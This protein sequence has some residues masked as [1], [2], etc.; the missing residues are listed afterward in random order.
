MQI[1]LL[2]IVGILSASTLCYSD[3]KNIQNLEG[4]FSSSYVEY[5]ADDG[6]TK[7]EPSDGYLKLRKTENGEVEFE[8]Y[9]VMP[10]TH[11][12]DIAGVAKP[13]KNSLIFRDKLNSKECRLVMYISGEF[14][15]FYD[16]LFGECREIYCGS[17]GSIERTVI[18]L[19]K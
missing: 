3:E 2:F 11:S 1:M 6:I 7:I 19:P 12:C 10:N 16:S 13:D 14:I 17:Q 8:L 9:T 4:T 18:K 5:T 15:R